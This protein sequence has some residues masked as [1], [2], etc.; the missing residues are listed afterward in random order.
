MRCET[1]LLPLRKTELNPANTRR[2]GY[3]DSLVRVFYYIKA[4]SNNKIML[5]ERRVRGLL[6]GFDLIG[7]LRCDEI[8]LRT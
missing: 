8:A 3:W 5:D 2:F 1:T 7:G 4:T 6:V